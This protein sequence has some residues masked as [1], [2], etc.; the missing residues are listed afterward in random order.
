MATRQDL[1]ARAEIAAR[2]S[3]LMRKSDFYSKAKD[4]IPMDDE[5]AQCVL[6]AAPTESAVVTIHRMERAKQPIIALVTKIDNAVS[7]TAFQ[8][9]KGRVVEQEPQDIPG[10]MTVETW[11]KGIRE[12]KIHAFG[13]H[14]SEFAAEISGLVLTSA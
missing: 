12:G 11:I 8:S 5:G 6:V 13:A 7:L 3:V 1:K 9:T 4:L 10:A 14:G 2:F